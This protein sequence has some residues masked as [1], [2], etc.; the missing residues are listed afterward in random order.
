MRQEQEKIELS[1]AEVKLWTQ[2]G[3]T[4][5]EAADYIEHGFTVE[6]AEVIRDYG[7]GPSEVR[8]LVDQADEA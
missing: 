8:D 3:F 2:H 7:V 1:I 4:V 6:E 5:D